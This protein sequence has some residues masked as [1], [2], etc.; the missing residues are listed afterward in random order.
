MQRELVIRLE[1]PS[2]VAPNP[3]QSLHQMTTNAFVA[4]EYRETVT[5]FSFVAVDRQTAV[6]LE[7]SSHD[8]RPLATCA[9]ELSNFKHR[10]GA[11]FTQ[12]VVYSS[13]LTCVVTIGL[14]AQRGISIIGATTTIS[15]QRLNGKRMSHD[16]ERN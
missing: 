12:Q 11:M 2:L 16:S 15:S 3:S 9:T 6:E 4:S 14:A 7:L 1:T 8:V 13:Y 10:Y 5:G